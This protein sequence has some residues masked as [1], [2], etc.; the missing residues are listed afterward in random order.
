MLH[1]VLSGGTDELNQL[2]SQRKDQMVWPAGAKSQKFD[3][4]LGS[5]PAGSDDVVAPYF[6]ARINAALGDSESAD[7]ARARLNQFQMG[8][9]F[10][11]EAPNAGVQGG[12]FPATFA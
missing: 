10:R 5:S 3:P 1:S 9:R 8:R 11:S 12:Q 7:T 2:A 4:A 6:R